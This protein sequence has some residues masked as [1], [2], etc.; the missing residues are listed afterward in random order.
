MNL[1][2]N[3]IQEIEIQYGVP[4][5]EGLSYYLENKEKR[6][7]LIGKEKIIQVLASGNLVLEDHQTQSARVQ[8]E[9][10]APTKDN[11]RSGSRFSTC[12]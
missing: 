3:N 11:A 4:N 9:C 2:G 1:C 6:L 12:K 10:E 5:R 8:R 7:G